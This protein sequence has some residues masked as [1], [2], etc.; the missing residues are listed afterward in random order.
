MKKL[1]ARQV[2]LDFHTSEHI[3]GIG[4]RFNRR[5]FQQALKTGH[6]NSI[7]V[8]A[9][10]HHGWSYYPTKIGV[11]HPHLKI[12]LLKEQIEACHAIGVRAPIYY[13]LGWSANDVKNHPDWTVRRRDGS[14]ETCGS[15]DFK[16]KPTDKRPA[17][18]WVFLCPSGGYRDLVVAQTEEIC[19]LMPVDGLF[20]DICTGPVCWCENCRE[21]MQSEGLDPDKDADALAYKV[22]TWRRLMNDCKEVLRAR[23]PNATL[24]FNG[25]A[26]TYGAEYHPWD[27]HFE[28]EDLPTAW[29]GYNKF[30][31]RAKIYAQRGKDYL[32]MSGKFHTAWG[33]FGGFKHP[34]AI[35][36]E[37]ASMI[38]WGARCSFGDQVHPCGEMDMATYRNIGEAYSYVKRIE[39]YGLDGQSAASLGLWLCGQE[40]DDQGIANMLLEGQ[41][42]FDIVGPDSDL[43][44]FET[45]IL[46]GA[47]CLNEETAAKLA[48]FVRKGGSL[49]VVGESA[50]DAKRTKFLIDVG[51]TYIGP[52]AFENDYLMVKP[53]VAEGLV[54][55][56]FLN[57]SGALR[58]RVKKGARI[59][60]AIRE[61]YFDRTYGKYCSHQ[62]TPYQLRDASHP[63][64]VRHGR[65]VFFAHRLG[66]M[67]HDAGA[68][69][70][71]DLFLNGLRLVHKQPVLS[72][73]MPSC[74]RAN[75]IH[76][77]DRKRYVAHLL[78]AP[79]LQRGRFQVIE[80]LVPLHNVPVTLNVSEPIRRAYLGLTKGDLK[81]VRRGRQ[82]SV[83]VPTVQCHQMVVFE[84]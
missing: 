81:M 58:S 40:P 44:G 39:P 10:C 54:T 46:P 70:H 22:K 67:Y 32:A 79:P 5:Q 61:P 37:A 9:K 53:P 13:T 19:R 6:V 82:V 14:M 15:I 56:P 38:A 33:E 52:A 23:H 28:L 63:G 49:V 27:T 57:Y 68:R 60:A 84:Y 65:V 16:A 18:S 26:N 45:V 8:F 69:L 43:K 17:V 25:T 35:R 55:S 74:G 21:G 34:D 62:N 59:L 7:T 78:Y 42:D 83:T 76:Q 36:Y 11:R 4:S 3:T 48:G 77:P 31:P 20:Y 24:F 2:H 64:I 73:V 29:G 71:R 1:C 51:A 75:L 50:L 12:N 41:V 66:A 72:T 47:P 80:D 30:P